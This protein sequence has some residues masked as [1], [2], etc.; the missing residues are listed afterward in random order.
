MTY[1][2]LLQISL[3]CNTE[4]LSLFS[5]NYPYFHVLFRIKWT[6]FICFFFKD[7]V[8]GNKRK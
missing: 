6:I 3:L 4:Q 1:E 7:K 5:L 8:E 2:I